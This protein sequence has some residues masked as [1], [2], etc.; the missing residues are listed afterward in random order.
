MM[1]G[2][3]THGYL[4]GEVLELPKERKGQRLKLIKLQIYSPLR[5]TFLDVLITTEAMLWW[6]TLESYSTK[7]KDVKN[8]KLALR[9]SVNLICHSHTTSRAQ[10]ARVFLFFICLWSWMRVVEYQTA[11]IWI[12]TPTLHPCSTRNVVCQRHR[13]KVLWFVWQ[14]LWVML[15]NHF[16]TFRLT[17]SC[18]KPR[19]RKKF[20]QN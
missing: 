8:V 1:N 11:G 10:R 19:N 7:K 12:F 9:N 17:K 5:W 16:S 20:S 18:R 14:F 15:G 13:H 3:D 4:F 6:V 2:A